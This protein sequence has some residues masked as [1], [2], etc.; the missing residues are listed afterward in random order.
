MKYE[1]EMGAEVGLL[2]P[3]DKTGATVATQGV[4]MK[5]HCH[6]VFAPRVGGRDS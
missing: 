2:A 5:N 4:S 3:I 6:S 1:S